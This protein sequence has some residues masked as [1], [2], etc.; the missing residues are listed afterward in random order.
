MQTFAGRLSAAVVILGLPGIGLATAALAPGDATGGGDA[1]SPHEVGPTPSDV[2]FADDIAPLVARECVACHNPEGWAPFS[3][4]T[5]D[6]VRRRAD[7]I[8]EAT[9][10]RAMPPWLPAN[11]PGTFQG[12]RH[13]TDREIDLF[14][15]WVTEGTAPGDLSSV[16]LSS[17][18]SGW[19]P[20]EPDLVV[21]LPTYA[22]PAEGEDVYRNLVVSIP[23][24]ETRWVEYVDLRPGSTTA[25]HHARMMVDTTASSRTLAEASD[26]P[27]F[28]GM[29]LR[30]NATDPPGHFIGWT[31]GKTRLEPLEGMAWQ[32]D[33]GTDL[34]VQLH[35][36]TSGVAEEVTA[37]VEFHFAADP[38]T[39][40]P[41][42]LV[43]SS[44]MIDIPPGA[45]DYSVTNSFTLPVSVDVLSIYPH[46][47]YLGKELRATA[48]LPNGR[49]ISLIR[50]PRWDFNWQD[51]YRFARP[52]P[53][54]RGTTIVK[55]FSYDNSVDNPNN[56]SDPPR[57][58]VYGSNSD[59]EMADLILQ[60]LPRDEEDRSEL[61]AAQAW[62][63]ESEDMAYM[64]HSEFVQGRS[65]L[66]SGD[67][68]RATRHFQEALQ[69]RSDHVG[70]LVGL[71]R[72][73]E[74]RG[75]AQ[76]SLLIARQGV[77]MSNGQDA[78]ALDALAVAQ[79]SL[80]QTREALQTAEQALRLAG[81][82]GDETLVTSL[83]ALIERLRG[84]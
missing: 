46:A 72:V 79:A 43:I 56:P 4:T 11:E 53:L 60:V 39:R 70:S 38:P 66:D 42:I 1:A 8:V 29:E 73:F 74:Q 50:I 30:G 37:E 27:G 67:L 75:D 20:G 77:M 7:R 49:E 15:Q 26:G 22:L 35:L 58:V 59:D 57:R 69:Y 3:L 55:E 40:D 68:D 41:A 44:L 52:V 76:S 18:E 5:Y 10:S 65:A 33:P 14:R 9:R 16:D 81:D 23:V 24:T 32:L 71:A 61:L 31:P 64:A 54:P 47:H 2:T 78:R 19:D 80:G 51:D 84:G 48:I 34:V 36:R 28:D 12:E 62:Q 25:V 82:A 6:D 63:H 21:T 13:L 83:E 45:T 17:I